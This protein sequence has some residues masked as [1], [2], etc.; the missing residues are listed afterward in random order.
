M[1]GYNE[2][3]KRYRNE[4]EGKEFDNKDKFCCHC[5]VAGEILWRNIVE[6]QSRYESRFRTWKTRSGVCF[7]QCSSI[8]PSHYCFRADYVVHTMQ[9]P[10]L[11]SWNVILALVHHIHIPRQR[12][13][14]D[15]P[16]VEN[17]DEKIFAF[18]LGL[19]KENIDGLWTMVK[20]YHEHEVV[21]TNIGITPKM[22][23]AAFLKLY[24]FLAAKEYIRGSLSDLSWVDEQLIDAERELS[25]LEYPCNKEQQEKLKERIGRCNKLNQKLMEINKNLTGVRSRV[26]YIGLCARGL[27][28]EESTMERYIRDECSRGVLAHLHRAESAPPELPANCQ[29]F[30]DEITQFM[31]RA[32]TDPQRKT[33]SEPARSDL[34]LHVEN[35]PPLEKALSSLDSSRYT[36]RDNDKLDMI[37][38]AM[39]QYEV[40][41]KSLKAQATMAVGL[42][43]H[44]PDDGYLFISWVND[45][46]HRYLICTLTVKG[47]ST[48]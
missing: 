15:I 27:M 20:R 34:S 48:M 18:V 29:D 2:I 5:T 45:C 36:R 25:E 11:T 26:H 47:I 40:D 35:P 22:F 1:D 6:A 33:N 43:S 19:N 30:D 28:R 31:K 39:T 8:C 7:L 10:Y 16:H 23:V 9:V 17:R 12:S 24:G 42:V 32:K 21:N 44:C 4:L 14:N 38:R 3:P 46:P 41:I 13:Q 37:S